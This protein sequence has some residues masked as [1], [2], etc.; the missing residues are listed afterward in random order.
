MKIDLDTLKT[1]FRKSP[2]IMDL[3]MEPTAIG[4]GRVSTVLVLAPRHFQHTGVVHAGVMTT[5]ADHSMGAAA[6]S[7][8]PEGHWVLTA[9]LKVS[10]LRGAQGER[11]VCEA[12][13]LKPGRLVTFTEAEVYAEAAGGERTLVMKASATMAVAPMQR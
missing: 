2:F 4:D 8:A 12:H 9:E 7:V 1:V 3:G 10:L 11:L 6:Q 5:M 13:V